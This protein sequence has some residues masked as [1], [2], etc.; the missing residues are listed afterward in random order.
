V[1]T[2]EFTYGKQLPLPFK[3]TL[4]NEGVDLTLD[5]DVVDGDL[6]AIKI[7]RAGSVTTRQIDVSAEITKMTVGTG[8]I[9]HAFWIPANASDTQAAWVGLA[10]KDVSAGGLFDENTCWWGLGGNTEALKDGT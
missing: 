7:S 9:G 4:S 2:G 5:T 8:H 6:Y 1:S 10:I 3:F